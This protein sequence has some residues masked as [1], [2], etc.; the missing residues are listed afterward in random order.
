MC[1]PKRNWERRHKIYVLH[2]K[3][4]NYNNGVEGHPIAPSDTT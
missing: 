2:I 4:L 1:I 3:D